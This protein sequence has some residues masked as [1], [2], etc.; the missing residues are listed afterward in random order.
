MFFEK[1]KYYSE[2][3]GKNELAR[4]CEEE[5]QDLR[6][7]EVSMMNETFKY[8][9]GLLSGW[10]ITSVLGS[11][12]SAITCEYIN[13]KLGVKMDYITQG[14]DIIMMSVQKPDVERLMQLCDD[15]GVVTH[16][17]KCMF[18]AVGEFLKYTYTKNKIVALPARTLRSLAYINPWLDADRERSAKEICTGWFNLLSRIHTIIPNSRTARTICRWMIKDMHGW[19]VNKDI[20]D[21]SNKR[22]H[23]SFS[24]INDLLV[25]PTSMGGLGNWETSAYINFGSAYVV[26]P[27]L[28]EL[29]P[30]DVSADTQFI[31]AFGVQ[32]SKKYRLTRGY[33]RDI[34]Y[35][36]RLGQGLP[37][38]TLDNTQHPSSWL[39]PEHNYFATLVEMILLVRE[40]PIVRTLSRHYSSAGTKVCKELLN[41]ENWPVRLRYRSR[42]QDVLQ[43]AMGKTQLAYPDSMFVNTRYDG[44]KLRAALQYAER[45][46]TSAMHMRKG[47]LWVATIYLH[48]VMAVTTSWL[49][50][51]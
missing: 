49:H 4:V 47:D 43:W 33:S 16:P 50:S 12:A 11:I 32:S 48:R 34:Y 28:S 26:L 5:I 20:R 36:R 31:G 8:K 40:F 46:Y 18:G 44:T 35:L 51:L 3:Y 17:D 27:R 37:M 9:A 22:V 10:R 14:D 13:D 6:T 23:L 15:M 45:W 30:V 1:I 21:K 38:R 39:L 25:T 2:K 19:A 41:K 29:K 7:L 24:A 42:W